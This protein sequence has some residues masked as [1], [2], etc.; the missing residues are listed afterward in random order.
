MSLRSRLAACTLAGLATVFGP[1]ALA[2]IPPGITYQ[3]YL[4][5]A[6]GQPVE[7]P[8]NATFR[9]YAVPT[10]GSPMWS[11]IISLLPEQGLFQAELGTGADAFPPDIFDTP[12]WIGITLGNDAEMTPRRALKSAPYAHRADDAQTLSGLTS[13]AFMLSI[14]GANLADDV[15][16]NAGN[17]Q[18]LSNDLATT[19]SALAATTDATDENFDA[20]GTIEQNLS[21]AEIDIINIENALPGLQARV[22]GSCAAGSSIR[23]IGSTGGV[24]CEV[25]NTGPWLANATDIWINSPVGIN[26]PAPQA[27]LQVDGA[28]GEDALRVRVNSS[29]RLI[30]REN[31]GV[32]VGGLLDAPAGGLRV[33]GQT[34]L[35]TSTPAARA[36]ISDNDW[37]LTLRNEATG[38]DEW[39]LGSSA[40][41]WNVGPGKFVISP[42]GSS[43]NS[44]L[45]IDAAG[46]IG[47]D[48]TSPETRLHVDGGTDVSPAGGSYLMLGNESGSNI[49][50]DNNEIMARSGGAVAPLSLNVEGGEVRVNTGGS[51][52]ADALRVRGGVVFDIGDENSIVISQAT[53]ARPK[54]AP[55]GFEKG[56][57]GG[58]AT[59]F[60]S[61]YSRNFWA[62]G[63]LEY[64]SYSDESLKSD[65][66]VIDDPLGLIQAMNGVSYKLARHPADD[67][68]NELSA[69][70]QFDRDHQLGF[71]AQDLEKVLPQLVREE[72]TTGLKTVGYMGVIPVLVEAIKAQQS[73]IETQ[74]RQ[75]DAQNQRIAELERRLH[76]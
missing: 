51:R 34:G 54:I 69:K 19:A 35:G 61:V 38:G 52:T 29:T 64:R 4:S 14:D 53:S 26:A 76:R 28:A 40:D 3:G 72:E 48:A 11:Q 21:A 36:T 56:F 43:G 49:A 27:M 16:T 13:S 74:Q 10:G 55:D 18:T 8:V 73:Q 50:L 46:N 6:A 66:K 68:Q 60:Q 47:I 2:Q 20:I 30:V 44:S 24:Q 5:D 15:A 31:G 42:T 45:V 33:A 41:F 75:M 23:S 67:G 63:P 1:I 70:E 25:D 12:V 17:I 32:A 59:P 65:V 7:G 37:Q 9:M 58:S 22:I 39:Y 62:S 57:V 71:I